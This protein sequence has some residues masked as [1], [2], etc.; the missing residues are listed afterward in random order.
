MFF[1]Y[2]SYEIVK[3][4]LKKK[5]RLAKIQTTA[6]VLKMKLR[7]NGIITCLN[8]N[9]NFIVMFDLELNLMF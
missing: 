4:S 1:S 9:Y 5:E 7:H 2:S 3:W 8:T 6:P